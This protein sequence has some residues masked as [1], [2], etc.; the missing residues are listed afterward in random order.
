MWEFVCKS[1]ISL[2]EREKK[3][4]NLSFSRPYILIISKS[5]L[6]LH[7]RLDSRF[8]IFFLTSSYVQRFIVFIC[9]SIAQN[10][11]KCS[12]FSLSFS[13]SNTVNMPENWSGTN[14]TGTWKSTEEIVKIFIFM[15]SFMYFPFLSR[16]FKANVHI[17]A[18]SFIGFAR[19]AHRITHQLKTITLV[20][21]I[22]RYTNE[23]KKCNKHSE[24]PEN[25]CIKKPLT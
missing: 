19:Y 23:G 11:N 3:T 12:F 8:D 6:A 7:S 2:Q 14:Q 15:I 25:I 18:R 4:D 5:N 17:K 10:L 22:D 1:H 24:L 21:V 9:S 20:T 16:E 13:R